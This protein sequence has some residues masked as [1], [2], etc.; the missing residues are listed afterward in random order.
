M[1]SRDNVKVWVQRARCVQEIKP[2]LGAGVHGSGRPPLAAV[3]QVGVAV[4][5][6][7]RRLDVGGVGG[8]HPGLRHAETG[9]DLA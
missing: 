4:D 7:D 3:E 9:P 6:L 8:G 2:D 5:A 1:T